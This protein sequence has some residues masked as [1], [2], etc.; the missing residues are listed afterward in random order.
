M[1]GK[2][3]GQRSIRSFPMTSLTG[4]RANLKDVQMFFFLCHDTSPFDL[5]KTLHCSPSSGKSLCI[6][7]T[8]Q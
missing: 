7:S 6:L 2:K 3:S 4:T 5:R 1:G 8:V